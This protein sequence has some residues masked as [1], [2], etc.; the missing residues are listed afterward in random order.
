MPGQP[1]QIHTPESVARAKA[2]FESL[3]A[4]A[5]SVR[6]RAVALQAQISELEGTAGSAENGVKVRVNAQGACHGGERASNALFPLA[7][8]RE[9][10]IVRRTPT[11]IGRQPPRANGHP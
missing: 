7:P 3:L 8:R 10:P 4:E 2:V 9:R 1:P 11:D 6:S 5:E